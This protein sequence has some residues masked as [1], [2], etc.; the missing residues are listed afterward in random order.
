M[1]TR[2]AAALA[3]AVACAAPAAGQTDPRP[4][5]HIGVQSNPALFDPAHAFSNV[6][7][8]VNHNIFDT[9][10]AIDFD[11]GFALVP[12]LATEWKRVDA[13][14]LD[15]T[16]RQGVRFHNGDLLTVEDVVFTF[17]VERMRGEGAPLLGQTR[18]FLGNLESVEAVGPNTVRFVSRGPDALLEQRL[19]M[20]PSQIINRRAYLAA[21]DFQAWGRMAVGTGPY[22]VQDARDNDFVQLVAHDAYWRGRPTARS[23]RF[24]VAPEVAARINDLRT[25]RFQIVTDIPYDQ[26]GDIASQPQLEAVGG[27]IMNNRVLV[28][29]Q[30]NPVLKDVRVRRALA[31]A[32]DRKLIV[33][34]LWGNKVP[35]PRGNQFPAFGA[36]YLADWPV[37]AYD[38]ERARAL[39]VE[40]GYAGQPIEFRVLNN[41]YAN[42]V[43][44]AQALAEMWKA[45]GL[46]VVLQMKENWTQVLE[47]TPSRG[48]RNWSNTMAYPDPVGL[49][50]RLYGVR[51]PVQGGYKEWTNAEFNTLGALL[52]TSVDVAERQ[53]TWRR[54]MEILEVE[55]PPATVLHQFAIFYGKHRDVQ[56]KPAPV[57]YM[58][59]RPTNLA[60]R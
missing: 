2:I 31:L 30:N 16:L 35:V 58:D 27:P 32:I 55:D 15:V 12:G 43:L 46:N 23:V 57:E 48:I 11:A 50:W 18:P 4:A 34:T 41:Y 36:L 38:P 40:A 8:R 24:S 6:A 17:G 5:L 3:V 44:T 37:P 9:L 52:E 14:T 25:G 29:D 33:E 7:W 60:F 56:W 59:L 13:R 22:K 47:R 28:F 39:L 19:A 26:L 42:E 1:R 54:M 53:R 49:A 45:V 21:P 10:I 20:F 51:G